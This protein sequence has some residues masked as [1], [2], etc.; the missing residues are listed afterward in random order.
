MIITNISLLT[1]VLDPP[2]LWRLRDVS[3]AHTEWQGRAESKL[4]EPFKDERG[5]GI[6]CRTAGI[7]VDAWAVNGG[8]G[9]LVTLAVDV[10]TWGFESDLVSTWFD[11]GTGGVGVSLKRNN[12][13]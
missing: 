9:K 12:T 4:P 13:Y 11:T 8:I 2:A 1:A 5:T 3:K 7:I 6:R 10:W